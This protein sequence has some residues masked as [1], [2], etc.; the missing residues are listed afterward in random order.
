MVKIFLEE[1]FTTLHNRSES[2]NEFL[3]NIK[4]VLTNEEIEISDDAKGNFK[5]IDKKLLDEIFLS[6]NSINDWNK[7]NIETIIKNIAKNKK[8]KLFL[9]ASPIR[10]LI[11]GKTYSPSIFKILGVARKKKNLLKD[12]KSF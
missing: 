10:A 4:C 1:V 3:E 2:I 11:T 5:K 6:L 8:L 12:K 7:K 9:V